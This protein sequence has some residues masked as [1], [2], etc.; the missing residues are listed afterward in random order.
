M[1]NVSILLLALLAGCATVTT[2]LNDHTLL[3]GV[4]AYKATTFA[5][6]E[7]SDPV[8]RANRILRY[9][10]TAAE[11]IDSEAPTTLDSLHEYIS[12]LVM[13]EVPPIDQV[14]AQDLL[15]SL[16]VAL[17]REIDEFAVLTPE[18]EVSVLHIIVRIRAAA[19][20]YLHG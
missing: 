16:R 13:A 9:T 15:E 11:I 4:A 5:I 8:A 2:V 20:Y 1:K 17:A 3:A 10:D 7:S 12:G 19:E 6:E 14:P 18:T